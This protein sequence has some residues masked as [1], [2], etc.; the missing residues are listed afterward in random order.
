MKLLLRLAEPQELPEIL[1]LQRLSLQILTMPQTEPATLDALI[2]H[3]QAQRKQLNELILVVS[4]NDQLV[5]F[6]A[7][8]LPQ[9]QISGLFVHPDFV[10]Q[11]IGSE[12]IQAAEEIMLAK[13]RRSLYVLSSEYAKD[14]Y[15]K[16]GFKLL[17]RSYLAL[18]RHD[19]I[20]VFWMQKQLRELT[21]T[22]KQQRTISLIVL[23]VVLIV[24]LWVAIA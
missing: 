15:K 7:L 20:R 16:R 11:G 21:A 19:K 6:M 18:N 17:R 5:G 22:E 13:N 12:L 1:Q 10:R 24:S 9:S 23:G 3:Q 4:C 8:L 2:T 14:F